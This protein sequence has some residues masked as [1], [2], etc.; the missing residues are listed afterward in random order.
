MPTYCCLYSDLL[1]S[2]SSYIAAVNSVTSRFGILSLIRSI[3]NNVHFVISTMHSL[4]PN[5]SP[6]S[7]ATLLPA[8]TILTVCPCLQETRIFSI[9]NPSLHI[10]IGCFVN[11][12]STTQ[13]VF[14]T[15]LLSTSTPI[16][17]YSLSSLSVALQVLQMIHSFASCYCEYRTDLFFAIM[18]TPH[19]LMA[20]LSSDGSGV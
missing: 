12:V 7:P 3:A 15:R 14:S 4:E 16:G 13:S 10:C 8:I 1:F 2:R 19:I 11:T 5:P 17:S 9:S 18:V 6:C 20:R